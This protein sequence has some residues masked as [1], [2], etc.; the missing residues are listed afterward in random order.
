MDIQNENICIYND[1]KSSLL[2]IDIPIGRLKFFVNSVII[3]IL[4]LLAAGICYLLLFLT[5]G[6]QGIALIISAILMIICCLGFLY[7][8]FINIAKRNWD[9]TGRKNLGIWITVA[10]FILFAICMYTFPI[11]TILIYFIMLFLPGKLIKNNE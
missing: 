7:L 3:F 4:A 11:A 5:G 8:H 10:L 6:F 1:K 9:I 2:K